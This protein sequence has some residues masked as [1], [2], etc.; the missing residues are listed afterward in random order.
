MTGIYPAGAFGLKDMA[1]NVWEWTSNDWWWAQHDA[2]LMDATFPLTLN[3][4]G[5]G[6]GE[7]NPW[8]I[9]AAFRGV[10]AP[11]VR[12]SDLGFRCSRAP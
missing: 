4:M 2:G 7:V 10:A 9:R 3:N 5:G 6:W 1:G 11:S 12:S 8:F